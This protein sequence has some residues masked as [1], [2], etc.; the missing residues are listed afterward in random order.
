MSNSSNFLFCCLVSH[1]PAAVALEEIARSCSP[2]VA[3]HGARAVLFDASGL[4][5]AVGSPEDIAREVHGLARARAIDARIALAGT[6]TAA[7]LLAHAREG[8]TIVAPG[9]DARALN[10]IELRWL[11]TMTGLDAHAFGPREKAPGPR[12]R[13]RS[14]SNELGPE[15]LSPGPDLLSILARWGLRTLGDFARLPRA[16]V[17][18]RLGPMGVV[19]HQAACGE[20]IAAF[21]PADEAVRFVERLELEYAIDGLEPLSFV[22]A[23]LCESLSASLERADRGAVEL[24]IRLRLVTRALHDRTLHLP[25]P[26]R[27]ARVLRTLLLLDL[28][29]HPPP[30]AIDWVEVEAGVVP[31]AIVQGSLLARA[32]PSAEDL[33]TLLARLRALA[34]ESR[35]GAPALVDTHDARATAMTEFNLGSSGSSGLPRRSREAAKARLRD[36]VSPNRPSTSSG[37][38]EPA[39]GRNPEELQGTPGNPKEPRIAFRRFRLPITARVALEHGV[40]VRVDPAAQGL[41]GGRVLACAGP[42]RTSGRWWALDQSGWDRDEWDVELAD[43][44]VYRLAK[45]RATRQWVIEGVV[46]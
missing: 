22:L 5:Q 20:P 24:G 14:L 44:G 38:P 6:T 13:A 27:D 7:W 15:A 30:A 39:E 31:G 21:V 41:A 1:M 10:N 43:G 11:T 34:G 45:D 32:L 28:E 18:A 3:L 29:S 8:V 12:G 42:W 2:R 46:D 33:A 17:H 16:G 23:R 35:V 26:L 4:S 36:S 25:A 40:P 9:E 37:R 19:L